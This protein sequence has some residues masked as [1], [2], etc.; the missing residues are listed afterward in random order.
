MVDPGRSALA[1][2]MRRV[3]ALAG[4]ALVVSA[5]LA[6]GAS[7]ATPV[8]APVSITSPRGDAFVR[9]SSLTVIARV[10]RRVTRVDVSVNGR[11]RFASCA[12]GI[13]RVPLSRATGLRYGA[14]RVRV[15]ASASRHRPG[16]ATVLFDVGRSRPKLV[17]I[18]SPRAVGGQLVIRTS[19]PRARQKRF[20]VTLNG[21]A[22]QRRFDGQPG[23]VYRLRLGADEGLRHGRNTVSVTVIDRDGDYAVRSSSFAISRRVP[24]AGAGPSRVTRGGAPVTLSAR[25][26]RPSAAG[27]GTVRY[28]WRVVS[29]PVAPPLSLANPVAPVLTL[30]PSAVGTYVL[31][32]T[33]TQ[34]GGPDAGASSS[35]LVTVVNQPVTP[36]IGVPVSTLDASGGISVGGTDYALQ[37]S[38]SVVVAAFDRA[39]LTQLLPTTSYSAS[40][41]ATALSQLTTAGGTHKMVVMIAN[42]SGKA[43][44]DGAWA[45]VVAAAGGTLSASYFT[46]G[47]SG[48]SV[49]GTSGDTGNAYQSVP[50]STA[51]TGQMSG[52]LQVGGN[53]FQYRF[54]AAEYPSFT[55]SASAGALSN[56]MTINGSS[57]SS[58]PMPACATGGFQV[59]MVSAVTLAG[60][61][62]L[63]VPTNGC[64]SNS[65]QVNQLQLSTNL[66]GLQ[67]LLGP[68]VLVFVQSIGAPRDISSAGTAGTWN[69]LATSISKLGGTAQVFYGAGASANQPYSLVGTPGLAP[70]A[71]AEASAT[72]GGGPGTLAGLLR[73]SHAWSFTPSL[74]APGLSTAP[75][76]AA[77]AYQAPTPWPL[78]NDP[79]HIAALNSIAASLGLVPNASN[80]CEFPAPPGPRGLYCTTQ[81]W[82]NER[83]SLANLTYTPNP[84]FTAGEFSDAKTQLDTEFGDVANV[85]AGAA[86]LTSILGTQAKGAQVNLNTITQGVVKDVDADGQISVDVFQLMADLLNGATFFTDGL[87]QQISGALASMLQVGVDT[88]EDP[89]AVCRSPGRSRPR[90]RTW[91]RPSTP[92]SRTRTTA[93]GT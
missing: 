28:R 22:I 42:P 5:T 90:P 6:V 78:S 77:I 91:A 61:A 26:S 19:V 3:V 17:A 63:T 67:V 84:N 18:T 44:G 27:K 40:Q 87:S 66:L 10:P 60:K 86:Q 52:Y 15:T 36:P 21:R 23:P 14:N 46:G 51:T 45:K 20:V 16:R 80:S 35:D 58:T 57:Y 9:T 47:D 74:A 68:P 75:V 85:Y 54:V 56:T 33:A 32:L 69:I 7:A 92:S 53:G 65:D 81:N 71:G 83:E 93:S 79:G 59:V 29:G 82:A 39:T 12:A 13:C 70:G 50:L 64:G 43:L 30:T 41:A 73:R 31:R 34:T 49:I 48:F 62:N 4:G 2:S 8:T 38:D 24:I 1:I 37:G 25:S 76:V 72:L 88:G 55:T 11:T 89:R